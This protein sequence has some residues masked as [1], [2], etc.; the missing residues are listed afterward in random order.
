MPPLTKQ[1]IPINFARGL[2]TK[3][4][5]KQ[6]QIGSFLIL[7]NRVFTEEGELVKR[8]GFGF[9]PMPSESA[10]VLTTF[11]KNLLAAGSVLEA[12][13]PAIQ[14]WI[15]K[16]PL[17][18][19]SLST[20]PLIRSSQTQAQTDTAF[21]QNDLLCTVFTELSTQLVTGQT[22]VTYRYSVSDASTGENLLYPAVISTADPGFG[23]PK[24][25]AFGNYFVVVFTGN[26]AGLFTLNFISINTLTLEVSATTRI[27]SDVTPDT[28][29]A[30]DGL[31]VGGNLYLTWNGRDSG[32]SIFVTYLNSLLV[33]QTT[34]GFAGIAGSMFSMVQDPETPTVIYISSYSEVTQKLY[35]LAINTSLGTVLAPVTITPTPSTNIQNLTSESLG[36]SVSLFTEVGHQYSYDGALP[37]NYVQSYSVGASGAVSGPNTILRSVGLASKAFV[38]DDTIFFACAYQSPY[39]PTYFVSDSN[40]NLIA[41][42]AYSNGGGYL[43]SGLPSV[44]VTGTIARFAYLFKDLVLPVNKTTN[45][46]APG[47]IYSQTGINLATLTIGTSNISTTEAAKNVHLSAGFLWMYDGYT[48]VEHNFHLWPDSI[49]LTGIISLTPTGDVTS[50]SNVIVN[51][52]A[53][54]DITV[55]MNIT[56]SGIPANSV[57]AAILS[58]SSIEINQN[59]TGTHSAT[60]LTLT[61]NLS[62]QQYYYQVTYEWSDSQG[63]LFRSAPSV[64]IAV[65]VSGN[66]FV[67]V[68]IPTLRLTYKVSNPVRIIV[69]RWSVAQQTFFQVNPFGIQTNPA[70][71]PIVN[72]PTVDSITYYDMQSD[73]QIIGNNILYTTGGIVENIGA[74]AFTSTWLFK[75]RF[76]GIDA[77]DQ[78][79]IWFSKQLIESVP[80]ELSDLFTI[81]APP[82]LGENEQNGEVGVGF[83]M[84]DKICLFRKGGG[85]ISYIT[86]TGPDNTGAN[87]DFSEPFFITSTLGCDNKKSLALIPHGIMFQASLGKGVWLLGRDLST[88][89]IG[90]PVEEF[91]SSTIT[92][93]LNIPGTTQVRFT[94]D[95]GIILMYDYYYN[96]WGTFPNL[97]ALSSTIYQGLQ[98]FIDVSG[99]VYQET[100]GLYLDG[101]RQVLTGFTTGWINPAGLQGYLRSYFFSFLGSFLSPHKLNIQVAYDYASGPSQSLTITPTNYWGPWGSDPAWGSGSPWGTPGNVEQWKVNL[102]QQRCQAFQIT[103]EEVFDPSF[104]TI[105]GA[106][107]TL[108]GLNLVVGLKKGYVPIQ[109]ANTAG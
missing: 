83:P 84:D 85:G 50:G 95:S 42:I 41:K 99:R 33:Q 52:S 49:E 19:A 86:G 109:A 38:I 79:L 57:V 107:F 56:G 63:N 82:N 64:P 32:H 67:K 60:T 102:L 75:D 24:V 48:P 28:F 17:Q 89:Y 26:S 73:A 47:G 54:T 74:P 34:I 3:T 97:A 12:Y 8:N 44:N 16:G 98:T 27:S 21:S 39:Q 61:G 55:G 59:A 106:G 104:G 90:A 15:D 25:F 4:D 81:Y 11:N 58:S 92:S 105:P 91:N 100:P 18:T 87:N 69:Y 45:P 53:I 62:A 6:L 36:G 30:F 76:F 77:E 10:E 72:D 96:Q 70:A 29:Q 46:L 31:V 71:P 80:V 43:P 22:E 101:V 108:S 5:P 88:N 9:L 68:N 14:Q 65:T 23:A 7:K 37:T 20:S 94:L 66:S 78:N 1:P 35:V 2:D 51:V 13:S 103:M 93:A 40:G